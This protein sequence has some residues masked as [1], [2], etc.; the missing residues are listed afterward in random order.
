[1]NT[2]Y[3]VAALLLV[4]GCPPAPQ[5]P[6]PIDPD[7]KSGPDARRDGAMPLDP[8]KV[9]TDSVDTKQGDQ[10]DWKS[11]AIGARGTLAVDLDWANAQADVTIDAFDP[12]G[13]QIAKSPINDGSPKKRLVLPISE[14]G[15][16]YL[17]LQSVNP[18]QATAYNIQV[19][20]GQQP[21]LALP[22]TEEPPPEEKPRHVSAAPKKHKAPKPRRGG[23][24]PE[25]GVQGRVVSA[26]REGDATVLYLDKGSA[27]GVAVGQ[28]GWILDGP[29]GA[30]PLEG[31][32]FTITEV[33][34]AHRSIA[35]S[36]I[37]SIGRNNRIS[38]HTGK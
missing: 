30:T 33:V 26:H 28:N 9:Y 18:E 22:S 32:S 38:I 23:G 31:G 14:P 11:V 15:I 25:D 3:L 36:P 4:A 20:G 17:R 12:F 5:A 29:A 21:L 10:T 6:K 27:A 34:D 19:E 1:M 2:R 7:G 35:K 37:H 16:Y 8:G 24:R 13:T